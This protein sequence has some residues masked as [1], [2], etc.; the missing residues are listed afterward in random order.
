VPNVVET[1]EFT[2]QVCTHF[3][4]RAPLRTGEISA[5]DFLAKVEADPRKAAAL[6]GARERAGLRAQA[7]GRST[8]TALRLSARLSQ[9]QLA[10]KMK[11]QQPNIARWERE[12]KNM[13]ADTVYKLAEALGVSAATVLAATQNGHGG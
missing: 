8:L 7:N 10:E 13:T 5:V 4:V 11:T 9:T 6:A 3:Y 2:F 12:P 1:G